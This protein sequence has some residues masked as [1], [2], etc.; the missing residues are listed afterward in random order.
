[1]VYEFY[2]LDSFKELVE[3]AKRSIN[4]LKKNQELFF[5]TSMPVRFKKK[6]NLFFKTHFPEDNFEIIYTGNFHNAKK[7]K[8]EVCE[9]L[10]IEILIEN[11]FDYLIKCP[12]KIFRYFY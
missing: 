12:E 11:N 5:I 2:N 7:T 8:N 9:E 1:M 3:F 4:K 10:S 6:T